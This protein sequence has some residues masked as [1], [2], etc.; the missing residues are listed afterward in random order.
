MRQYMTVMPS[1]VVLLSGHHTTRL[2]AKVARHIKPPALH[3]IYYYSTHISDFLPLNDLVYL[4]VTA[5]LPK[6]PPSLS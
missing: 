1:N 3:H 4:T 5:C 6:L 2:A